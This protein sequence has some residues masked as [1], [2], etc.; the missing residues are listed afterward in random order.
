MSFYLRI[1]HNE[2]PKKKRIKILVKIIFVFSRFCVAFDKKCPLITML[3]RFLDFQLTLTEKNKPLS[4]LRPL[5]QAIDT[6]FYKSDEQTTAG[7]HIRDSIDTKRVMGLVV[8]ALLPCTLM[9]IWNTGVQ[10]LV[11]GS[12]NATLLG[13]YFQA[14]HS[15]KSYFAFCFAQNRIWSILFHGLSTFI[16]VLLI[17]YIVGGFWEVFFAIVRRHAI[18]EGFFVTGLLFALI[19][20]STI[21][22]WMVA[23]G[24]SIGVVIGKEIFGGTGMNIVNPALICRA[25]L[26]FSFPTKMTGDVWIGTNPTQIQESI[27]TINKEIHAEPVDGY[28]QDS[29]LN[30]LNISP[31]IKQLHIETLALAF[32]QHTANE[33]LIANQL[34]RWTK[35]RSI[36]ADIYTLTPDQR[37]EF[38]TSPI[39]E[40]GLGLHPLNYDAA[41]HFTR[42]KYGQGILTN[43]NFFFG[44]RIGSMGETSILAALLGALLLIITG[45]GSWRIMLATCLGAYLCATLFQLGAMYLAPY[46]GAWHP[47]KFFF[48]PYKQFLIGSLS[49]GLVFMATDPVSAPSLNTS[50]ILYGLIIGALTIVIRLINPAYSEGVMLAILF[51]NI[52]SPFLDHIVLNLSKRKRHAKKQALI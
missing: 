49:F 3:R 32:K 9:A 16:P 48:P 14:S 21:P 20:P 25:F 42:L 33:T 31:E 43:G 46:H 15:L 50:R 34:K 36:Q 19:L 18:S 27:A 35:Q 38:I 2:K 1:D 12:F 17:S 11:Y 52:L 23:V 8:L 41:V 5:A 30:L 13:D 40:G 29:M 44:N 24:V 6:F 22:F 28:S 37:K 47:A 51:A 39:P 26:F 10:Q 4:R 45:I 7:P